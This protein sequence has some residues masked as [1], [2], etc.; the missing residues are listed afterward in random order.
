MARLLSYFQN[1]VDAFFILVAFLFIFLCLLRNSLAGHWWLTPVIL[2]TQEAEIRRITVQSQP[3]Q[4]V[5]ETLSQKDHHKR[6]W[7][8]GSK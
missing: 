1:V 3:G 8:S 7:W 4:M 2:A 5:L 6:G